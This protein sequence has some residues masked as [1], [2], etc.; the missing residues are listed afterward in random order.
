[1]LEQEAAINGGSVSLSY[2]D[3]LTERQD[4]CDKVNS[5]WGLGVWCEPS[6][7]VMGGDVNRDGVGYDINPVQGQS[8]GGENNG[9]DT[10][11]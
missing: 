8:T 10:S 11:I 5:L 9:D 3:G 1:M 7:A 4:W 6:E 2:Q